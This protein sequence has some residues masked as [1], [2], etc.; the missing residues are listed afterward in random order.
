MSG[1][2]DLIS[3]G[4]A[5]LDRRE[6]GAVS[7]ANAAR[8]PPERKTALVVGAVLALLLGLVLVLVLALGAFGFPVLFTRTSDHA[9]RV[10]LAIPRGWQVEASPQGGQVSTNDGSSGEGA[11]Y[12]IPDIHARSW[13]GGAGT[14]YLDLEIVPTP[15]TGASNQDNQAQWVDESCRDFTNCTETMPAQGITID[16]QPAMEQVVT[17]NGATLYLSTVKH[18]S[19]LIRYRG[20]SDTALDDGAQLRRI[21]NTARFG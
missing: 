14:T 8:R 11:A 5:G 2:N 18:G 17:V 16:G 19:E 13:L 20:F 1:A 4:N 3:W 6:D 9:D 10:S 21:W 7:T 15:L 12:R